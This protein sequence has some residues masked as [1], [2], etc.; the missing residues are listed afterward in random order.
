M[1]QMLALCQE[2]KLVTSLSIPSA[3]C[4]FPWKPT[5]H[6]MSIL[7]FLRKTLEYYPLC[8]KKW[9]VVKNIKAK[10]MTNHVLKS[11]N[12]LQIYISFVILICMTI[13]KSNISIIVTPI[14]L[15]EF[16]NDLWSNVQQLY[17]WL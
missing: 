13:L 7:Y 6:I 11:C 12:F 8:T 5:I 10:I 14:T 3:F 15:L 2:G 9:S 4:A 16:S 1:F 17:L